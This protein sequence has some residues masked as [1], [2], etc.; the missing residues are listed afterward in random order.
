MDVDY[1]NLI[2]WWET[3]NSFKNKNNTNDCFMPTEVG[4]TSH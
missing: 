3:C 2:F 1:C 4:H